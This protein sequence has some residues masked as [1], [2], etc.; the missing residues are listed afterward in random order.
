MN[1]FPFPLW[2][3][4]TESVELTDY[5]GKTVKIEKGTKVLIP[6]YSLH[7]HP[8]HYTEPD[9]FKPERFDESDGHGLKYY[10]DAG[11]FAP[12]GNGPRSCLGKR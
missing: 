12:F 7:L 11:L 5:D 9:A 3:I 2:K 6:Y 10:K 1:S 4:C 8:E